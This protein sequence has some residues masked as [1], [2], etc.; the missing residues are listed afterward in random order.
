[1]ANNKKSET[2]TNEEVQVESHELEALASDLENI[3]ENLGV[4]IIVVDKDLH[5]TR[6]SSAIDRIAATDDIKTGCSVISLNWRN[7]MPDL[8]KIITEVM[9]TGESHYETIA[10]LDHFYQ[11]Q[12]VPYRL[13]DNSIS[14]AL[15]IFPDTTALHRSNQQF[16]TSQMYLSSLIDHITDGLITIDASDTILSFNRSAED[17]F[18]YSAKEIIGQKISALMPSDYTDSHSEYVQQ[19]IETG[20]PRIL[21]R[22][23]VVQAKRNNS[24]LFPLEISVSEMILDG[25]Q[26]FTGL[27]RDVTERRRAEETLFQE[28]ERAQVTLHSIA[29]AVISTDVYGQVEYMNPVA[30]RLT[31]WVSVDAIGKPLTY[32]L[33]IS[34]DNAEESQQSLVDKVLLKQTTI[35]QK[36]DV[37]L[38][39]IAG[40]K[41]TIELSAAPILNRAG[42]L[43][44]AVFVFNDV[45]EKHGMLQQMA[46]NAKHDSLTGLL[47]RGEMERRLKNALDTAKNLHREHVLLYID[48]DQFKVVNDTCG[49][50]AGDELL[51]QIGGKIAGN[52]R[53]RDTLARLGGDEFGVLMENCTI[54][55][56]QHIAEKIVHIIQDF[57]FVWEDKIFRIGA[58]IGVVKINHESANLEQIFADADTACYTAKENGRNRAQLHTYGDEDLAVRRRE[59]QWV[60]VINKAMDEDRFSLHLQKVTSL[61]DENDFYWEVLLR[62][63]DVENNKLVSPNAFLPAAERYGLMQSVDRWVLNNTLLAMHH[64]KKDECQTQFH[65][66]SVN[67]SGASLMDNKFLKYAKEMFDEHNTDTQRLCFEI[68]ETAAIANFTKARE[69]IKEMKKLGCR[70]ALDDFGSGMSSFGYLK[71]L[72]VDYIKID[73]SFVKNLNKDLV[74]L[75]TVESINRIGHL[76]NMRTVAEFA[77]EEDI[78]EKLRNIGVDYAQGFAI[79]RP[80]SMETIMGG[81]LLPYSVEE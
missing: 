3:Q 77:E 14:G 80:V 71:N 6:Y 24:E 26:I 36:R 27:V 19:Y 12:V 54:T 72:P 44:G 50:N 16:E 81:A 53:H 75:A 11:M 2:T 57:R 9:R 46:W 59:M 76:M 41:Y 18:G 68:T 62:M 29:D 45:S 7:E 69:F 8:R 43:I 38:Q 47:N 48:L 15:L 21:G 61:S 55:Q 1:M 30:E 70:F 60:T 20:I 22:Q 23:R 51:R 58:S 63:V 10:V 42:D 35:T 37:K 17:I 4:P 52:L 32:V 64:C 65:D 34:T 56:G 33:K 13:R 28:K 66:F 40:E 5:I 78:L 39:A 49:H 31:G 67:L 74:D 79:H 73:G 25:E